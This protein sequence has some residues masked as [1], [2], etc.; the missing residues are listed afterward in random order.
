MI[1]E[2]PDL[3]ALHGCAC[4]QVRRLSRRITQFALLT[5]LNTNGQVA[6]TGL[7]EVLGM[8]R[9]TLTRLL[10]PLERAGLVAIAPSTDR[11][12]R[13]ISLTAEGRER[14]ACGIPLWKDAYRELRERIGRERFD[15]LRAAMGEAS[16]LLA[17]PVQPVHAA[18]RDG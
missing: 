10:K 1:S 11:R 9:T 17:P 13:V 3:S 14:F 2:Q 16:A 6:V 15:A 7:A 4:Y 5:A 12:I 8:D 18:A